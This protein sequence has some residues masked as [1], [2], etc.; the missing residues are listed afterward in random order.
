MAFVTDIS[1]RI[2]QD[3]QM[4]HVEKLAA[5][6]SM[7]AG[8]ATELNNPVGIILSRL[9][10]MLL[11]GEEQPRSLSPTCRSSTGTPSDSATSP[12]ASSHSAGNAS[13]ITT[14]WIWRRSWRTR[15]SSWESI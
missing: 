12:R 5:L 2:E 7:A 11:Q 4:R 13:L 10:V 1:G 9:E 15:S 3:R 6:G 8:I 14:P